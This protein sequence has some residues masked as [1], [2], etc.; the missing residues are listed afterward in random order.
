MFGGVP[1]PA[2]LA[3]L[4]GVLPYAF[5]S[6]ATLLLTWDINAASHS[7]YALKDATASTGTR[8]SLGISD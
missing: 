7:A 5:A 8:T 2:L 4:V 3:G 6:V 1:E